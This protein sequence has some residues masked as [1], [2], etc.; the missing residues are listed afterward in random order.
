MLFMLPLQFCMLEPV[1]SSLF[2]I[3]SAASR[4]ETASAEDVSQTVNCVAEVRAA[5]YVLLTTRFHRY[6][7]RPLGFKRCVAGAGTGFII[8]RTANLT[9]HADTD[10]AD[11][12]TPKTVGN[13]ATRHNQLR[14]IVSYGRDDCS[15]RNSDG[16][17]KFEP[18][19]NIEKC[20]SLFSVCGKGA[21]EV[22]VL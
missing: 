8:Q 14:C 15:G 3:R 22:T 12:R 21:S 10:P 5:Y 1:P 7:T 16:Q 4:N 20:C 19:R 18:Y 2:H 11:H 13:N 6:V 9:A 17:N